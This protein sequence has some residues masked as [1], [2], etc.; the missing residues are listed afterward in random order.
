[1][2]SCSDL[3]ASILAA[4]GLGAK[5]STLGDV[6]DQTDQLTFTEASALIVDGGLAEGGATEETLGAI[7]E[8]TDKLTF[9]TVTDKLEVTVSDVLWQYYDADSETGLDGT[10]VTVTPTFLINKIIVANTSEETLTVE[11]DHGAAIPVIA[12]ASLDLTCANADALTIKGE[13]AGTCVWIL[14]GNEPAAPT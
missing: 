11:I 7:Q 9:N 10:G 12:G 14:Q 3:L 4:V 1:M 13:S 8:V 6:K 5:E 2:V